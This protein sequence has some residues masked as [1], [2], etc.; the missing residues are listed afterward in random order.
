[1]KCRL[2]LASTVMLMP[3]VCAYAQ[4]DKDS[5]AEK[6]Y[7]IFQTREEYHAFMGGLKSLDDPEIHA[8]L[9]VLNDIVLGNPVGQT[10]RKHNLA[11]NT[12]VDLLADKAIRSELEVVDYQ[13]EQIKTLGGEIQKRVGEQLRSL[14]VKNPK[15][16]SSTIR[17]ITQSVQEDFEGVLLP[18]QLA[19]LRQ[20]AVQKQMRRRSVV[21]VLTTDPLAT[22]LEITDEQKKDLKAAEREIEEELAREIAEL[23]KKARK[24]LLSKLNSSQRKQLEEIVGEDFQFRKSRRK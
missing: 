14:D 11:T 17:K 22:K 9:P 16:L 3:S 8:M 21:D 24:K 23:R 5:G 7:G 12:A 10:A 18:H 15:D 2:L 6:S 20:L 19:R 4:K 13:Y 1:M